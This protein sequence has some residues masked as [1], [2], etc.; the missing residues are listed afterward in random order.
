M[1]YRAHRLIA[2]IAL[3]APLGISGCEFVSYKPKG[4]SPLVPIEWEE[5]PAPPPVIPAPG[6]ERSGLLTH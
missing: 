1:P 6:E 4:G 5:E 3:L 2:L